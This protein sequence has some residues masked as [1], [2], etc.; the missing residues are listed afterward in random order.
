LAEPALELLQIVTVATHRGRREI[1]TPQPAHEI[2][3]PA[4]W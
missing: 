1:L 4:I 3:Q 2:G